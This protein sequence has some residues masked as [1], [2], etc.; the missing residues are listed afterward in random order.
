MRA[1][2]WGVAAGTMEVLVFLFQS[3][4]ENQ[5][6]GGKL[7]EELELADQALRS[8]SGGDRP[9]HSPYRTSGPSS[10]LGGRWVRIQGQEP[11]AKGQ[12]QSSEMSI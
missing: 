4:Q 7:L 11:L 6:R 9:L 5:R 3:A 10:G 2:G 1:G 8:G 12:I